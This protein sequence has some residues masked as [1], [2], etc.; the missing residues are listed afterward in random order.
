M[1]E[2]NYFN[3][4]SANKECVDPMYDEDETHV[5]LDSPEKKRWVID[6]VLTYRMTSDEFFAQCY[7]KYDLIF[8]DGLH[9]ADQVTRD[10]V[11]SYNHLNS[12]GYIVIHDCLP[13]GEENQREETRPTIWNGT[14]WKAIPNLYK[15]GI[16]YYVVDADFGCGIIKYNGPRDF[17]NYSASNL[18]YNEVFDNIELR[19]MIMHVISEEEFLKM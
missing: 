7:K 11:N 3:V 8:I 1:P 15:A 14:T 6:T 18:S 12:G 19:N 5:F 17:A 10:I 4:Y 2:H 9:I 13:P 16:E